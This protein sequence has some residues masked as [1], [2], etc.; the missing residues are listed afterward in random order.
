MI[1]TATQVEAGRME[2]MTFYSYFAQLS[3]LTESWSGKC[4]LGSSA[5]WSSSACGSGENRGE[6]SFKLEN[7]PKIVVIS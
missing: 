1:L 2:S 4:N 5:H 7:I 3:I 6:V